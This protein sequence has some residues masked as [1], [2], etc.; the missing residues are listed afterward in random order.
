[1]KIIGIDP[2]VRKCGLCVMHDGVIIEL[3]CTTPS[4]IIEDIKIYHE[5]GYIFAIEDLESSKATYYR[6]KQNQAQMM[7]IAQNVGM[8]K[9]AYEII[10]QAI[11]ECTGNNPFLSPQGCGK[12]VKKDK[13]YFNQISGWSENSNEDKRDAWAVANFAYKNYKGIKNV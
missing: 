13:D 9:G 4:K 5:R 8:A 2:D 12:L 10:K 3:S 1:M 7:K 6:G 11:I